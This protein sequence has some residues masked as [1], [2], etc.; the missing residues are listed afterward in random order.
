[1][2]SAGHAGAVV[3]GG[4]CVV[5]AGG[6]VRAAVAA[7]VAGAVVVEGVGVEVARR[8][9]G[10]AAGH[11]AR[12]GASGGIQDAGPGATRG[13]EGLH[14]RGLAGCEEV[15]AGVVGVVHVVLDHVGGAAA[16]VAEG[17]AVVGAVGFRGVGHEVIGAAGAIAPDVAEVEPV[18]HLVGSGPA[19]VERG[20]RGADVPGVLIAADH[21]VGVGGASWELGVSEQ[22]AAQVADPVV[23][24][25]RGRPGVRSAL[26]R[27][28]HGVIAAE[29]ADRGRNPQNAVGGGATRVEGGEAELDFGVG[30]L[31]P[32]VVLIGI[33]AAEIR[34]QDVEL[35]LDLGVGNVLGAVGVEDVEDDR[36]G[37]HHALSRGPLLFDDGRPLGGVVLDLLVGVR[38][39]R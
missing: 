21:A 4:V 27:E 24:V 10:A 37:H 31:G 17:T 20:G 14:P 2:R 5:V 12:R 23:Q 18:A 39:F 16:D 29:A 8:I 19:E 22:A 30:C 26:A 1:M 33:L 35:G 3:D 36:N 34:I 6:G 9:V 32:D 11:L 7:E 25:V 38:V 28:F 13:E 15:H